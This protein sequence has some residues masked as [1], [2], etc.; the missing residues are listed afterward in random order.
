MRHTKTIEYQCVKIN[1]SHSHVM[2]KD[3]FGA[4]VKAIFM[5]RRAQELEQCHFY[6]SSTALVR[7]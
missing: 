3:R 1:W 5:K 2:N 6:D 7:F 4:G